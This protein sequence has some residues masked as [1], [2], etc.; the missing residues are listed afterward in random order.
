MT[1]RRASESSGVPE[2]KALELGPGD[3]AEVIDCQGQSEL[4]PNTH[5]YYFTSR[6]KSGRREIP[7]SGSSLGTT[8]LVGCL[9]YQR[10]K[11]TSESRSEFSTPLDYKHVGE[12]KANM[13]T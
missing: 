4:T 13:L 11:L 8:I 10:T 9:F 7:R 1:V 6:V 12:Y 3:L 5:T 2:G